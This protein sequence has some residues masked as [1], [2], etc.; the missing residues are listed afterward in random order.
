MAYQ[1]MTIKKIGEILKGEQ[2]FASVEVK[3]EEIIKAKNS[4][5]P[6]DIIQLMN[7]F[8]TDKV[9]RFLYDVHE[10]EQGR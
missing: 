6:G 9:E 8:G 4:L 1:H 2:P 3:P 7:E 10:M 5:Q